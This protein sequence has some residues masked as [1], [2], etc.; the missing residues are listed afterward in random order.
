[1]NTK[2]AKIVTIAALGAG[3]VAAAFG[4]TAAAQDSAVSAKTKAIPAETTPARTQSQI[5][6][7]ADYDKA[8]ADGTVNTF[9]TGHD[10]MMEGFWKKALQQQ[11]GIK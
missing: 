11:R 10:K 1:M 4:I 9:Q 6:A 8:I 3:T 2:I 5:E 7:Q